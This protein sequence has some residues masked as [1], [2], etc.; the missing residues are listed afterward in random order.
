[1]SVLFCLFVVVVVCFCFFCCCFVIIIIFLFYYYYY[2]YHIFGLFI[3]GVLLLILY[4]LS[5]YFITK[6]CLYKFDPLKPHFY[7]ARKTGVYR[8]I[9]CF[10]CFF[11]ISAQN[12]D[13]GYS[14][15]HNL[16]FEQKYEKYQILSESFQFLEVKFSVYLNRRVFEVSNE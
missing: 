12:I 5:T 9:H 14:S 4:N 2:Y 11:F 6:T 7:I 10:L 1:M 16:C 3:C 13:C 8:S 15:T